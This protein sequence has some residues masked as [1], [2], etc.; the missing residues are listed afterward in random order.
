MTLTIQDL[1]A[2]GCLRL[3]SRVMVETGDWVTPTRWLECQGRRGSGWA[4]T[5][6]SRKRPEEQRAS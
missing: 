1:G 3:I 4:I 2:L 6:V 5:R